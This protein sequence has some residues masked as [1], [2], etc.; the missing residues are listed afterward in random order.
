MNLF[1]LQFHERGI[2]CKSRYFA[3][4][5]QMLFKISLFPKTDYFIFSFSDFELNC[6]GFNALA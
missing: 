1:V 2:G 3:A 6:H 5:V 4:I